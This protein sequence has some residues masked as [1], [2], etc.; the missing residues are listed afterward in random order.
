MLL[1]DRD[2]VPVSDTPQLVEVGLVVVSS[3][4]RNLGV[5]N[6]ATVGVDPRRSALLR[7]RG[8]RM[9][10]APENARGH[11]TVQFAPNSRIRRL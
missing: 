6:D 2:L 1:E 5:Q 10:C 4:G 7:Q 3:S 11:G 8:D 9:A